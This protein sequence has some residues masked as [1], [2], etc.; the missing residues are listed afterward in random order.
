MYGQVVRRQTNRR[1]FCV[2]YSFARCPGGGRASQSVSQSVWNSIPQPI[3]FLF[4]SLLVG[5]TNLPH[6]HE[7]KRLYTN[8]EIEKIYMSVFFLVDSTLTGKITEL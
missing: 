6:I 2:V 5:S 3:G 1:I 4:L 7:Y 8:Q